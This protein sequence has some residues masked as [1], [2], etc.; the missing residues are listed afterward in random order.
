MAHYL[1]VRDCGPADWS[2]LPREFKKG[3]RVEKKTDIYGLT[4]DDYTLNGFNTVL[5][6]EAGRPVGF[7]VLASLLQTEDGHPV[8]GDYGG[9]PHLQ[10]GWK[11]D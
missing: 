7:T 5:V 6:E 8:T 2:V 9:P 11:P 10:R 1:F 3:E 4:R